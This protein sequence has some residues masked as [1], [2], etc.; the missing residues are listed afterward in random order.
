MFVANK[1]DLSPETWEIDLEE[2]KSYT[3]SKGVG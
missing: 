3:D 2:V 1:A